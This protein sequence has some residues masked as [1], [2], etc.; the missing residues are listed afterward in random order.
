MQ[1]QLK[2]GV[3]GPCASGKSTLIQ[4]L[5]Q[6]GY[7]AKHIVQEH[8]YVPGMWQLITNPDILIYLDVSYKESLRRRPMNWTQKDFDQ[9]LDR[10]RH[11]RINTNYYLNTDD[12]T[13]AEVLERVLFFLNNAG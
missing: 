8:S 13:P 9:E 3:V 11:A 6:H 2:I 5:A 7:Q 10:L 1:A 12:L 4:G